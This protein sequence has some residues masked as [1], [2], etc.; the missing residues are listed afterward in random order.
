MENLD[1]YKLLYE[2]Q[3][4]QS[5]PS[6]PAEGMLSNF[7]KD[8]LFSMEKL[9]L[10]P[11]SIRRLHPK[12]DTLPFNLDATISEKLSGTNIELLH[13][14]GRL[15]YIDHS[16]QAAHPTFE[17]KNILLPAVPISTLI[18]YRAVSYRWQYEPIQ[19]WI[20]STPRSILK[21]TG[22]LQRRC[23]TRTTYSM[24]KFFTWQTSTP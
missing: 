20:S 22:C 17:G 15:F 16:Y 11:Y 10:N 14:S 24:A 1:S 4:K 5:V 2:N 8:R 3:W 9:S 6:G 19:A 12:N 21:K 23:S 7:T 13:S 18:V